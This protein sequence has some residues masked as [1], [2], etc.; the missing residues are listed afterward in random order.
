V[1]LRSSSS[2][3]GTD[4]AEP[5]HAVRRNRRGK[6]GA[7]AARA[8]LPPAHAVLFTPMLAAVHAGRAHVVALLIVLGGRRQL[9]TRDSHGNNALHLAV[10]R[11]ASTGDGAML[12]FL[13]DHV[14][15]ARDLRHETN[16]NLYRPGECDAPALSRT[17]QPM[18]SPVAGD[19]QPFVVFDAGLGLGGAGGGGAAEQPAMHVPD[20]FDGSAGDG[21]ATASRAR[22]AAEQYV[23][24]PAAE[25]LDRM[26]QHAL[27]GSGGTRLLPCIQAFDRRTFF[28]P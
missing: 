5:A 1:S 6:G 17:P 14:R 10:H 23:V 27:S 19:V 24:S 28:C 16:N 22:G 21:D 12:R 7:A 15:E 20:E 18:L 25:I 11:L 8:K 4:A 9:A 13:I 3:F 26:A 2:L